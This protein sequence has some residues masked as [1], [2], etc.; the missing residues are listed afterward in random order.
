MDDCFMKAS[1]LELKGLTRSYV[2]GDR[3]LPVLNGI[4]LTLVA[5]EIVALLGKSG[6]GKSTLLQ[7]IGL[8]DRQDDGE[9]MLDGV[10]ISG[11]SESE[12]T[13]LRGKKLGFIYQ[14]HHLL[15]EFTA[16]ENVM[17]PMLIAGMQES[18]AAGKA[19]Q[20][21]GEVGLLNRA[22]QRPTELSGGEQQRVAIARA[23]ANRPLLVL[24]D[25]PT[26]NLDP[27]TA[28]SMFEW[29]LRLCRAHGCSLLMAT[30][31]LELARRAD[32]IVEIKSGLLLSVQKP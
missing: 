16:L 11:A 1:V 2:Q 19:A 25:E 17:M 22:G 7:I 3:V 6:S 31:N 28:A 20:L 5:G 29:F 18:D 26:G 30:H 32:R 21:I 27:A 10:S 24:A 14:F 13:H 4:D 23:F 8:L 12:R 9:I 15:P